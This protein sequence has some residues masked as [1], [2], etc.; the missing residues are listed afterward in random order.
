MRTILIY[1]LLF[2]LLVWLFMCAVNRASPFA[3]SWFGFF[4]SIAIAYVFCALPAVLTGVAHTVLRERGLRSI[5]SFVVA[6]I[7]TPLMFTLFI[8]DFREAKAYAVAGLV[9]AMACW[10][11]VLLT[12]PR[13]KV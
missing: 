6:V 13:R 8:R 12:R 3:G 1:V 4:S 7:A 9:G 2:P 11:V 10:V 5:L